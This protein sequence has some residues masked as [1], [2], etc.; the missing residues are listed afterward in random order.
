MYQP[1]FWS[2][3]WLELF[4][5][6]RWGWWSLF[7]TQM[8]FDYMRW[9]TNIEHYWTDIELIL[10]KYWTYTFKQNILNKY[11]SKTF[12]CV[13]HLMKCNQSNQ[14]QGVRKPINC[15]K[16]LTSDNWK[17]HQGILQRVQNSLSIS[18]I[19]HCK[20]SKMHLWCVPF[21]RAKIQVNKIWKIS[22]TSCISVFRWL[23]PRLSYTWSW[24]WVM[25][26][27]CMITSWSMKAGWRKTGPEN[28]S[29]R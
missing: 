15:R 21:F 7:N 20:T 12:D 17:V 9:A 2:I 23:T 18:F 19:C 10:N 16:N 5:C 6:R 25:G 27:T 11:I 24:S 3:S 1:F 28:I 26:A 29:V 22:R 14:V 8:W 13:A 4:F